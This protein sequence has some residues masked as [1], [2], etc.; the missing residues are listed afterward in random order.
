MRNIAEVC[1]NK[2]APKTAPLLQDI[3]K[4]ELLEPMAT[5]KLY[6][7]TH[8]G[9]KKW[10]MPC[11]STL[12]IGVKRHRSTPAGFFLNSVSIGPGEPIKSRHY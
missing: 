9:Q 6:L 10:V 8:A 11:A 5:A 7:D 3:G 4:P 12:R 1:G 2:T